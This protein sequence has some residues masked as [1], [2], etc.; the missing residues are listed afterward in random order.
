MWETSTVQTLKRNKSTR[1][2]A[3]NRTFVVMQ[4]M[5]WWFLRVMIS[6]MEKKHTE[7]ALRL[8]NIKQTERAD[9]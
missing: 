3:A 8:L 7:N 4:L 1:I 2:P 9:R 5:G 6:E